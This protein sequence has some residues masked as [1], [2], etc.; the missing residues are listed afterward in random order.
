MNDDKGFTSA[1]NSNIQFTFSS[2]SLLCE[3]GPNSR[4][5]ET[6][7]A[8]RLPSKA[9]WSGE[10]ARQRTGWFTFLSREEFLQ[11][12]FQNESNFSTGWFCLD[13]FNHEFA[14]QLE[15]FSSVPLYLF[16]DTQK[17]SKP[18]GN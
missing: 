17:F 5:Q 6:S 8:V 15:I 11:L 2:R 18:C 13:K 14:Q 7:A 4:A 12:A 3:G 10:K 16:K 9:K 1:N